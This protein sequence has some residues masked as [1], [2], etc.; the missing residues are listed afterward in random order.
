MSFFI[1]DVCYSS[2]PNEKGR[3]SLRTED[4]RRFSSVPSYE[5]QGAHTRLEMNDGTAIFVKQHESTIA[6]ELSSK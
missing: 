1:V 2:K 4:V 5:H 6:S 3:T